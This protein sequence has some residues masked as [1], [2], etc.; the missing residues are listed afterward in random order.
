MRSKFQ[1]I[2]EKLPNCKCGKKMDTQYLVKDEWVC[3]I[4]YLKD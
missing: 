1:Q 4:C 2:T 3:E